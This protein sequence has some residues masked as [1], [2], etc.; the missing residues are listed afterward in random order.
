MNGRKGIKY[1]RRAKEERNIENK[2]IK[3]K[4]HNK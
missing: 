4:E 2:I 1:G 3:K